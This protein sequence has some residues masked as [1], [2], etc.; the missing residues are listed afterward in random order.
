VLEILPNYGH[1][2]ISASISCVVLAVCNYF[3]E[4]RGLERRV[5]GIF[6]STMY[7][8]AAVSLCFINMD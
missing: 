6:Q 4:K 5:S 7:A 1:Y 8:M 2:Y 3:A